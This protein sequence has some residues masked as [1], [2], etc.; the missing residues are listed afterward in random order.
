MNKIFTSAIILAAS[1]TITP[2]LHAQG[3]SSAKVNPTRKLYL[4]S[5]MDMCIFSTA[6]ME[7]PTISPQITQ[8]R[9]TYF[10]NLGL[11]LNYN[12]SNHVGIFTG[13]NMKNIGFIEKM[14]LIDSTVKRRVLTVGMPLGISVGNI[15]K[16]TFGFAGGGFDLPF[17]YKEKGYIRRG[18]K[19]K[20]N[21]WFSDRTP[22][23]MPYLFAGFCYSPGIIIKFQY[24]PGN[25]L[26][27]SYVELVG[28][29]PPGGTGTYYYNTYKSYTRLN[30]L[31]MSVGFDIPYNKKN[32]KA[33]FSNMKPEK[34]TM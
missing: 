22:R 1:L 4:S 14:Q 11:R 2:S 31:L 15:G 12:F 32:R 24:Y 9:F 28:S 20:F 16:H 3:D 34:K 29:N 8:L 25:F 7:K 10:P 19:D 30:L 17:N 27:T 23:I 18:N 5:G 13:L 6:I 26:N 21:E 33:A